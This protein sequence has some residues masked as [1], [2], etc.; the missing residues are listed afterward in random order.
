MLDMR[1]F[2][3]HY[4]PCAT[5]GIF[6]VCVSVET[7]ERLAGS[8]RH[9]NKGT[10]RT[11]AP[12]PHMDLESPVITVGE[13]RINDSN[14]WHHNTSISDVPCPQFDPGHRLPC[15]PQHGANILRRSPI[16]PRSEGACPRAHALASAHTRYETVARG[17]TAAAAWRTHSGAPQNASTAW[18][19][20][21]GTL[22]N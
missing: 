19:D 21:A 15:A 20:E 2:H 8:Q 6:A 5:G 12:Q 17:E 9:T 4:L 13:T 1:M 16:A 7:E 22:H 3:P 14:A 18:L 11:A 10:Q